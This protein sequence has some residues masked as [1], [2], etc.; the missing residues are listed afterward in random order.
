LA[1]S[2]Y[3]V[4]WQTERGWEERSSGFLLLGTLVLSYQALLWSHL[5]FISFQ[6][7]PPLNTVTEG[8]RASKW[9]SRKVTTQSITILQRTDIRDSNRCMWTCSQQHHS[10]RPKLEAP[11]YPSRHLSRDTR[12]DVEWYPV[13]RSAVLAPA[14]P[15]SKALCQ[16]REATRKP[17]IASSCFYD[18]C[19]IGA[20]HSGHRGRR[21]LGAVRERYD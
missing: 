7:T 17:P 15:S 16:A 8:L 18:I 19:R 10:R 13:I 11:Q 3:V 4:L 1:I 20:C 9:V 5:I 6:K 12:I 21:S 14:T 2:Y